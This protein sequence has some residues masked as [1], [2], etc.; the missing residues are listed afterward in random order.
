LAEI[1]SQLV[2][3]EVYSF[4]VNKI[5]KKYQWGRVLFSN[6]ISAP[7]DSVLF[8]FLAFYG[9]QPMT[10]IWSMIGVQIVMKW[11]MAVVSIPG[12]YLVKDKEAVEM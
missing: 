5:T 3:T 9:T 1:V 11:I 10:V 7:I 2:D 12:I 8:I 4:Y 6:L